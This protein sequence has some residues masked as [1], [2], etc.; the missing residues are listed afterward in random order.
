LDRLLSRYELNIE[1]GRGHE[2]GGLFWVIESENGFTSTIFRKK[3]SEG[4]VI[5]CIATQFTPDKEDFT[6]WYEKV[7]QRRGYLFSFSL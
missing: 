1:E 3:N 6:P 5:L 7:F 2:N 4:E